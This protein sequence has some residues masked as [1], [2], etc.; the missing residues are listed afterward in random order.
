MR[1]ALVM[2]FY[3]DATNTPKSVLNAYPIVR[4]L[5]LALRECG[6]DVRVF[7]Q[8]NTTTTLVHDGITYSFIASPPPI[9]AVARVLYRW[10][11]Y[12]GPAWYEPIR[13]IVAAVE[14]FRPDIVH[15]FGLI[16]DIQLAQI[17]RRCQQRGFR[18]VVHFHGGE[19][20]NGRRKLLQRHNL[21]RV[22]RAL[23]TTR[24]QAEQWI[25]SGLLRAVQAA[26]VLETSTDMRRL[27]RADARALT[28]MLGD[29]VCV[30]VGRLHPVKDPLTMLV[31]FARF[32]EVAPD[33]RLYLYYLTD[34]LLDELVAVVHADERLH[35]A[36]EFRGRAATGL[37]PAVYSSADFLLQASTREWSGLAILEALA[38]GCLPVV[39]DIPSFRLMTADGRVGGLFPVGDPEA[40]ATALGN[41]HTA[42]RP[43]SEEAEAHFREHLSFPALAS[44]I[45]AVYRDVTRASGTHVGNGVQ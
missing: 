2:P 10:R 42:G 7:I 4:A 41:L 31:G 38:C 9:R 6:H 40:L 25:D 39:S 15:F 28:G 8:S 34:E 20:A 19:P 5:P 29:P 22:D 44:D 27:P 35:E 16:M 1:I 26:Q 11:G 13:G 18:L 23:F 14:A 37:M 43:T 30:S 36:V 3:S 32:R 12:L 17:A 33:A 21:T 45:D 24:E